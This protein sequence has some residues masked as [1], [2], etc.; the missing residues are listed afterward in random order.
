MDIQPLGPLALLVHSGG[1]ELR[2]LT[3][4]R[5]LTPAGALALA[6]EAL[7]RQGIPL[8]RMEQLSALEQEQGAVLIVQLRAPEG[9]WFPFS[10]LAGAAQAIAALPQPPEGPLV[11]RGGYALGARG[12]GVRSILS[13][14]STP[15]S[16]SA[17]GEL[18]AEGVLVL[19]AA[20][21]KK[22]WR[23]LRR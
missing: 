18:E 11:W 14:F 8:S 1:E 12:E 13:G 21:L 5:P 7:R 16:P 10:D 22:L 23:A 17:E 6:R 15:L 4:S 2:R 19:D 9:E 20:A 3:L